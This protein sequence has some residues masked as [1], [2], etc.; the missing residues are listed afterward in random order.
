MLHR[1][2]RISVRM[3]VKQIFCFLLLVCAWV[4]AGMSTLR[5]QLS[6]TLADP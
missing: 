5:C 1:H 6:L 4:R 2:S 3:Y